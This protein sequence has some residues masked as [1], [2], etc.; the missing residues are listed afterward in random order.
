MP[1]EVAAAL[2]KRGHWKV[3]STEKAA[4]PAVLKTQ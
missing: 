1:K 4:A 2:K 3:D